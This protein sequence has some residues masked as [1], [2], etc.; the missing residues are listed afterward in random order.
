[1]ILFFEYAL[2]VGFKDRCILKEG[3]MMFNTLISQFLNVDDVLCLINKEFS[4][5]FT[6]TDKNNDKTKKNKN[7][8]NILE[9]NNDLEEQLENA[10]NNENID[11]ALI[12]APEEDGI[13]KNLTKILERYNNVKN[14]GSSSKAIE[15]AGN[16]YLTYKKIKNYVRTPKTF[17]PRRYVIKKIDGC[18]G[19]YELVNEGSIIQEYIEGET[20]SVSLIVGK[21]V[22]PISLNRQYINEKGFVGADVNIEHELKEEIFSESIKAVNCIDGLNGYVGVDIIVNEDKVYVV[23]INP[24]ITTSICGIDTDPSLAELLIKNANGEELNFKVRGR[25]FKVEK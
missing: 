22:Y 5:L 7:N 14:L 17:P 18:G 3:K 23:E 21:K 13:L 9:I 8:L 15:I 19:K 25:C 10:L 16:K 11:Y 4:Q 12:I 6:E 24:R 2:A 1:M 20:L